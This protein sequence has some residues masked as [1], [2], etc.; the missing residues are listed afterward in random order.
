MSRESDLDLMHDYPL[1]SLSTFHIGGPARFFMK[2]STINQMIKARHFINEKNLPFL[3]IGKGSNCL[4]DD[5]GFDGLV[6]LNK[7]S[8]CHVDHEILYVGAGYRLSHLS[9]QMARQK[10]SGLEFAAGIPGTVGGAIYMNA[11]AHGKEM[12]QPLLSVEF[13][14]EKGV[15]VQKKKEHLNFAYR[16][17]SFQKSSYM[18][19]A[20]TFRLKKSEKVQE[21]QALILRHRLSTQPYKAFSAGCIFRNPSKEKGA[22]FLIESCGLKGKQ[23]GGAKVSEKH[24]NFIVNHKEATARDVLDLA[25]LI[26]KIVREQTGEYLEMEIRPIPYRPQGT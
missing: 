6:I 22:G 16:F 1:A 3:V 11:G 26:Q 19:V 10:L 23:I 5:R 15:F 13:V 24:A 25:L 20:A 21:K 9:S 7:I 18:I 4:F 2:V 12:K 17:S 14:D 8:F